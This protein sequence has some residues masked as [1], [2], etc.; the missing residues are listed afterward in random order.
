MREEQLDSLKCIADGV[1]QVKRNVLHLLTCEMGGGCLRSDSTRVKA[2]CD[3]SSSMEL[4]SP[5]V[6][7]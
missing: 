7:G 2:T 4:E 3:P 6:C 1:Q 5:F